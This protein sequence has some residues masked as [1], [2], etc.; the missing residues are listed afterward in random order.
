MFKCLRG[1]HHRVNV[2][3]N[4][5][6]KVYF[7]LQFIL[8]ALRT[9]CTFSELAT[10]IRQMGCHHN[11]THSSLSRKGDECRLV[12]SKY[13][14]R[15]SPAPH[16][17]STSDCDTACSTPEEYRRAPRPP[18]NIRH[19]PSPYLVLGA[20]PFLALVVPH[21]SNLHLRRHLPH[22][23]RTEGAHSRR[24]LPRYRG[25][26]YSRR[27]LSLHRQ[28]IFT[29]VLLACTTLSTVTPAASTSAGDCELE[30]LW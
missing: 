17:K 28:P 15:M 8:I 26:G 5:C 1:A 30:G 21:P 19:M 25:D 13:H 9:L 23:P 2:N 4:G 18:H 29:A 20:A 22:P 27:R 14:K 10:R 12:R 11:M 16:R 24:L 6:S 7:S 3:Y